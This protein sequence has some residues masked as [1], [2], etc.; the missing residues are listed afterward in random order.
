MVDLHFL[1]PVKTAYISGFAFKEWSGIEQETVSVHD[2]DVIL[3]QICFV[4]SSGSL[5]SPQC[6]I[7]AISA[8]F[9]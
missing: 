8:R 2:E 9:A 5:A 7:A 6:L 1:I 3:L 4:T